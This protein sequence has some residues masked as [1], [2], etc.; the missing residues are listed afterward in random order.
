METLKKI[1]IEQLKTRYGV[2]SKFISRDSAQVDKCPQALTKKRLLSAIRE[3][4]GKEAR[5]L[6]QT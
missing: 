1:I 6:S 5:N 2:Y 4:D 3:L